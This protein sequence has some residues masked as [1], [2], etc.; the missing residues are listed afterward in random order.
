[1]KIMLEV[2]KNILTEQF[3]CTHCLGRQFALLG[4]GLSDKER[5]EII[6]NALVMEYYEEIR[7]DEKI[8]LMIKNISKCN[9]ELATKSYHK[10]TKKKIEE[11]KICCRDKTTITQRRLPK[12]SYW[13]NF[14]SNSDRKRR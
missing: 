2:A 11:E 5:G 4:Y 14:S 6:Q 9:N 1:L 3:L 10:V 8:S 13:G 12:F 7:S